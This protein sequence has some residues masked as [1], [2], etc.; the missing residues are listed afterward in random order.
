M[1]ADLNADTRQD[2]AVLGSWEQTPVM[3]NIALFYQ[4]SLGGMETE[5]LYMSTPVDFTGELLSADMDD[6]GGLDLVLKSAPL[7][8]AVIRQDETQTPPV[9]STTPDFYTVQTSSYNFV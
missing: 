6:D 5:Q 8:L 9:F 7:Q 2:L 3:G 1:V 4:N